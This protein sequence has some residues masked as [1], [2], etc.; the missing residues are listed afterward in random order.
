MSAV[1]VACTATYR[2]CTTKTPSQ[3]T[4]RPAAH[5]SVVAFETLLDAAGDSTVVRSDSVVLTLVADIDG[6]IL[7]E[8][9]HTRH[10]GVPVQLLSRGLVGSHPSQL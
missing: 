5:G 10:A 8:G 3:A 7:L 6:A 9:G 4:H 2:S 1:V